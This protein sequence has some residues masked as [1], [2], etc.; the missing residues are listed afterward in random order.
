MSI[1]S[2][3]AGCEAGEE[4]GER[5]GFLIQLEFYGVRGLGPGDVNITTIGLGQWVGCLMPLR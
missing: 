1:V 5:C 2:N 4:M 3:E